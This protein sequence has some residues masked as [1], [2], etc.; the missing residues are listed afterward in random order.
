MYMAMEFDRRKSLRDQADIV[1]IVKSQRIGAA[2][3]RGF[4]SQHTPM[5]VGR[6]DA[7]VA[8]AKLRRMPKR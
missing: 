8:Q 5:L 1:E 6:W 3:V 7:L 4:L 2:A